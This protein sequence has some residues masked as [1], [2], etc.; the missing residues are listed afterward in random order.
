[1]NKFAQDI[2]TR[3]AVVFC[4]SSLNVIAAGS[5]VGVSLTQAAIMA[6]ITSTAF[7][8][9]GLGRAYLKD[10]RLSK[11]EVDDVFSSFAKPEVEE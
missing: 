1:M 5:I 9:E 2:I 4:V 8:L 6:G 10:G 3:V 7:V 11:S